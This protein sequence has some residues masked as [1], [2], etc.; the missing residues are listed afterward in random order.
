MTPNP[1]ILPSEDMTT[2]PCDWIAE[3]LDEH[4]SSQLAI[5]HLGKRQLS[6]SLKGMMWLLRIY[7]VFMF[8]VVGINVWRQLS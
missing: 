3:V 6:W 4:R 1:S 5:E 2:E 7:V 8:L